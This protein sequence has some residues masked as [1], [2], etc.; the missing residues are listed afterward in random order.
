MGE[1]Q[2]E[3]RF[4]GYL[5]TALW[6]AFVDIPTSVLITLICI[7]YYQRW[8]VEVG[9]SS[10]KSFWDVYGYDRILLLV[11]FPSERNDEGTDVAIMPLIAGWTTEQNRGPAVSTF[12]PKTILV[13]FLHNYDDDVKGCG[14]YPP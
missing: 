4:V 11:R 7:L 2:L 3:V 13:I 8:F 5:W 6:V 9:L 10:H 14:L 12:M 1:F